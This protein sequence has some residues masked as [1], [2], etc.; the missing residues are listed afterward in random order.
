MGVLEWQYVDENSGAGG[1][2][3]VLIGDLRI[4]TSMYAGVDFHDAAMRCNYLR[5]RCLL[6][7]ARSKRAESLTTDAP[8]R[9]ALTL[10]SDFLLD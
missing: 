7:I 8:L 6:S 5:L 3:K 9:P 4:S 10:S 1:E 2:G